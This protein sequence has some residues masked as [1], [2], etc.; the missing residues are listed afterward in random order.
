MG[1]SIVLPDWKYNRRRL[2]C[3]HTFA[4]TVDQKILLLLD[5]ISLLTPTQIS[6][7]LSAMTVDI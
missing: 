5:M 7:A 3:P 2:Y 1:V 4:G 6:K